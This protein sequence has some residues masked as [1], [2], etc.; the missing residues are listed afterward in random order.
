MKKYLLFIVEGLNDKREIQ[1]IIRAACGTAFSENYVDAYHV[2]K[3]DITAEYDSSEKT[4]IKKLNKIVLDWRNGGEQP[5]QRIVPSD[6]QKII[7]IVDTDGTFIPEVSICQT[8]DGKIQYLETEIHC[9]DRN[10]TVGRNRKKAKV[11]RRLLEIKKIDNI[12]YQVLFA[13]CNMDHLLFDNRNPLPNDKGRNAMI[14]A[15]KCKDKTDL[16]DSIFAEGIRAEGTYVDSWAMIQRGHN[17]LAR[18]SN[19]NLLLDAI[20]S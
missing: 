4:I 19:I 12:P 20:I 15:S 6:V 10:S 18:H 14:F 9:C 17:S 13:S 11:I 8:D 16:Q 5:F 3:G 2:H 1:A 7:H